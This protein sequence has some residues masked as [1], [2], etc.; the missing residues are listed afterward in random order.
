MEWSLS[1]VY[2]GLREAFTIEKA[3]GGDREM[4]PREIWNLSGGATK[5][6]Y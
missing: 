2:G 6:N 4:D 3:G 1:G 5:Q